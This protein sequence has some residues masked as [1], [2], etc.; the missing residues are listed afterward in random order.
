MLDEMSRLH[1]IFRRNPVN[2]DGAFILEWDDLSL[3]PFLQL[4]LD[5]RKIRNDK[6]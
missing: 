2:V 5:K 4:R 3:N 1:N 6:D